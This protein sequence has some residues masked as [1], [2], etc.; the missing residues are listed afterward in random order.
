M[1]KT[2]LAIVGLLCLFLSGCWLAAI[3]PI[4]SI[5]IMWMEGEA[6]KYYNSD[7]KT[8]VA[9]M[10]ETLRELNIPLKNESDKKNTHYINAGD[11]A[12]RFSIKI[13]EVRKDVTKVCIRVDTMGDKP[14][15]EL[16]YR[17]LD[18]KNGVRT[19]E[20]LKALNR[21]VE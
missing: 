15:A 5:G 17:H 4:L 2:R 14:Y 7:Q 3:G 19:F 9:A 18:Q 13:Y 11:K 10:H 20:S 8:M 1:S 12:D 16:I 6:T 21:A